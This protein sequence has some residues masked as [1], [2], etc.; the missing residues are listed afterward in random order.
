VRITANQVTFARLLAIPFLAALLYGG[1]AART[2]AMI[3]GIVVGATDFVDGYLARKYGP[4]VLGGLM[5]PI[6]DKVFVVTALLPIVDIG[7]APWWLAYAILLRE[8]LVTAL[9]SSFEQ[10][11]LHL[12]STYLAK[13]KTWVQMLALALAVAAHVV[14]R[15][16]MVGL[17]IV[18]PAAALGLAL[19]WLARGRVW[20]GAWIFFGSFAAAGACYIGFGSEIFLT[21]IYLGTAIITWVSALDYIVL[22]LRELRDTSVGDFVR[23]GGATLV[24]I[25]AVL[26]LHLLAVPAW[27]IIAT[28]AIEVAH[29]GLDNLLAHHEATAPAWA[30]AG[31]TLGTAALLGAALV[32]PRAADL[33][34]VAALTVTLAG[35][36]AEFW[37]NRAYYLEDR[38][39]K[40]RKP[41]Q[42]PAVVR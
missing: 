4:T 25:L 5:D 14:P 23:V 24:P 15:A 20:R 19:V 1:T 41:V 40:K 37:R 9:R 3:L 16:G 31:R 35:T 36:A 17:F 8:F 26:D 27:A 18:V 39:K 21:A 42:A 28:V 10:R 12:R 7:W 34:A 33:L 6:A 22:A 13:V 32:W 11:D 29:G 2:V 38:P 30:W